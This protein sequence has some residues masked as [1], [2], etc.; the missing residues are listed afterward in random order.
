MADNKLIYYDSE[1]GLY[2][3]DEDEIKTRLKE[4]VTDAYGEVYLDDNYP[5]GIVINGLTDIINTTF[6]VVESIYNMLDINN[7]EGVVLD[8]IANVRNEHRKSATYSYM[9]VNLS[10]PMIQQGQDFTFMAGTLTLIDESNNYW[11]L[12]DDIQVV[13]DSQSQTV[14]VV[15]KFRSSSTGVKS[16]PSVVSIYAMNENLPVDKDNITLTVV[17]PFVSGDNQETDIQ[18]RNRVNRYTVFN[19]VTIKENLS[20]QLNDL[21][22]LKDEKLYFNN[23]TINITTKGGFTIPPTYS[24]VLVKP[25][26]DTDFTSDTD[27]RQEVFKVIDDYKGLGSLCYLSSDTPSPTDPGVIP[28]TD[29]GTFY[30]TTSEDPED[31][32]EIIPDG[33]ATFFVP[34]EVEVGSIT[35]KGVKTTTYDSTLVDPDDPT[36]DTVS[37]ANIK[38]LISVYIDSLRIGEDLTV[39]NLIVFLSS[40]TDEIIPFNLVLG[41]ASVSDG[42][43]ANDDKIFIVDLDDV[44]VEVV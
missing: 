8:T 26:K 39:G 3:A 29:E 43:L 1:T 14:S 36:S 33:Q 23:K 28:V 6:N 34:E 25:S 30:S 35:V 16:Q 9:N 24:L 20:S 27:K 32:T 7:A 18:F 38:N 12:N 40:N 44:D 21:G 31:P 17:S 13:Y 5:D 15:G 19:S 2:R 42:V 22:Y 41:N 11:R 4:I 10:F 37:I